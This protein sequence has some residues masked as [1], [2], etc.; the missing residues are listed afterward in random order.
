LH[1]GIEGLHATNIEYIREF[2]DSVSVVYYNFL[3]QINDL[4][5]DISIWGDIAN[6]SGTVNMNNPFSNEPIRNDGFVDEIHDAQWYQ[7]TNE[8][9]KCI[10]GKEPFL[11]LPVI[12]YIDKTGTDVNQRNKLEP[13]SFTL[14]ILNEKCPYR[15]NAWRVLGFMPDLEHKSSAAISRGRSGP[16]GK[17]CM[18]QN[19][20]RCL[21]V[22][23]QS[24]I[25]NQG[26]NV[27]I[28]ATVRI[29]NFVAC[30]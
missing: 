22:I 17:G 30:H 16:V 24:F 27:P 26:K 7:K 21:S 29:G 11:L 5:N 28:Y 12:G 9:C 3:D 14:S 6:F 15:S 2:C 13:F 18:A 1:I 19:Y 4:L 10:A 20:H 25:A 23:L 8:Q